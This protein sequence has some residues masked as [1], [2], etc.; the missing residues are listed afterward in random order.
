MRA[1]GF[2][3]FLSQEIQSPIITSFYNPE[4]PAYSFQKFYELQG[5]PVYAACIYGIS[6]DY[7][8]YGRGNYASRIAGA[9]IHILHYYLDYH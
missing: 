6:A 7:G 9:N 2:T 1:L 8:A 4:G 3:P 5:L